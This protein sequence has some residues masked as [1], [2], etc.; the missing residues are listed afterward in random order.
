M[1][2]VVLI[3]ENRPAYRLRLLSGLQQSASDYD[4]IAV[5]DIQELNDL[6]EDKFNRVALILT[7]EFF[8]PHLAGIF[9]GVL[10]LE[11][12]DK[13]PDEFSTEI[14]EEI[15]G[16]FSKD[17]A[18]KIHLYLP[19]L[20]EQGRCCLSRQS[21]VACIKDIIAGV[22]TRPLAARKNENTEAGIELRKPKEVE[23]VSSQTDCSLGCLFFFSRSERIK[24][25]AC[26]LTSGKRKAHDMIYLP[27]MP[28]YDM[29]YPF[30]TGSRQTLG[31]LLLTI[32]NGRIPDHEELGSY[33][34]LHDDGYYTFPCPNRAD[35]LI[36][37]D[38]RS[39]RELIVMLKKYLGTRAAPAHSLIEAAGLTLEKHAMLAALCDY[40]VIETPAKTTDAALMAQQELA[41]FLSK[42]P[43]SCEIYE[44]SQIAKLSEE[45]PW[46]Y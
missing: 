3:V 25:S 26:L 40:V 1:K 39:L 5:S 27:L 45:A 6:D 2:A 46:F 12:T 44:S 29:A 28:L 38:T 33:L 11:L 19:E 37:A 18:D 36:C 23:T 42:L 8:S 30:R 32:K 24:A 13:A 43:S 31:D 21:S 35:D 7:A 22:L 20:M 41:I 34:Y 15:S 16:R 14:L 10:R 4:C 9:P 17:S